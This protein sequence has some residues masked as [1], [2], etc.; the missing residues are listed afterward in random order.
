MR[1]CDYAVLKVQLAAP[2]KVIAHVKCQLKLT[3]ACTPVYA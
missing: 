1:L 2:G 3:V